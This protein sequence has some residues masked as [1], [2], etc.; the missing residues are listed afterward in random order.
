[1]AALPDPRPAPDRAAAA[2][3]PVLAERLAA[4]A[5]ASWQHERSQATAA[6][7]KA[8]RRR[9]A[10]GDDAAVRALLA[11]VPPADAPAVVQALD[12][13]I[14]AI[15]DGEDV[16]LL[17]RLFLLP[18]LFVT[19]GVASGAVDGA[20]PQIAEVVEAMQ[21]AAALGPVD[22]FGL[23]NALAAEVQVAQVGPSRLFALARSLGTQGGTD[24]LTPD[25][26]PLDTGQEQVHLRWLAGAA[27]TPAHA[28]TFVETAGQ[29]GRWG[30]AVSRTLAQQ[31]GVPG[32]SLLPLPRAPRPWFAALADG[33][34]A[35]EEL[36]FNLFATREIRR[37]RAEAGDPQAELSARDDGSVRIDLWSPFEPGQRVA[38]AW[39]LDATTDLVRVEVSIR[40]LLRDC[41]VDAIGT[42]DRVLP[43][44]PLP[45]IGA[46]D[47]L[48][49]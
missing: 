24:L 28:P 27:V 49:H 11:A 20:V 17:A 45:V 19:A 4:L 16:A 37:F 14:L 47:L 46:V 18:V 7:T 3:D 1:M 40:D 31:L 38:H 48:R 23:G 13:A 6:L 39:R 10:A 15:D 36:G 30:M 41:R 5:A 8:L 21:R 22:A 33:R 25:A 35:R 43:A 29:V 34:F 42:V 26:I 44:E 12:A 32:L 2:L 9:L